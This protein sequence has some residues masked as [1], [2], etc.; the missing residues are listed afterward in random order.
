MQVRYRP[1]G[2]GTIQSTEVDAVINCVGFEHRWE[3]IDD[4]LVKNLLVRGIVRPSA[5]GLG[6]DADPQTFATIDV[7]G[8][9]SP[10]VSVIGLPLRGVLFESGTIGELLKQ[11]LILAPRLND[12]VRSS[13]LAE[14]Q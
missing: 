9:T 10:S 8:R 3:R 11:S 6:V 13:Q 5:I 7:Q 12:A 14:V 1:R 2:Q 4:P